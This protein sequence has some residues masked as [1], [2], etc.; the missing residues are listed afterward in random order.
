MSQPRQRMSGSASPSSSSPHT[1][2]LGAAAASPLL[3]PLRRRPRLR[4]GGE[5]SLALAPEA[6]AAEP[7]D[8]WEA[9]R[10]AGARRRR[11]RASSLGS[12]ALSRDELETTAGALSSAD[13]R[14]LAMD[15]ADRGGRRRAS[16]LDRRVGVVWRPFPALAGDFAPPSLGVA[17]A[18]AARRGLSRAIAKMAERRSAHCPS[19]RGA[20]CGMLCAFVVDTSASMAQPGF[21]GM[22]ALDCAKSI[23]RGRRAAACPDSP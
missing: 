17:A 3:D 8:G 4:E 15:R 20:P 23:V 19:P 5:S 21:N 22:S 11:A 13:K 1:M 2:Q 18:A 10:G 14:A 16:D 7:R 6:C 12:R 9:R